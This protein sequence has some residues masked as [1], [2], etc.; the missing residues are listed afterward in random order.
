MKSALLNTLDSVLSEKNQ[1]KDIVLFYS[2]NSTN[3]Y[4]TETLKL[5]QNIIEESIGK[6]DTK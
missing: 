3:L 5:I 6:K 1:H 4:F 2:T